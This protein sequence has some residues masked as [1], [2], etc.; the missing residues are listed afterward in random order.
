LQEAK[1][2]YKWVYELKPDFKPD[3]NN[4]I[5]MMYKILGFGLT[6]RILNIRRLFK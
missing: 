4:K 6:E 3:N 2:I 5:F 1:G